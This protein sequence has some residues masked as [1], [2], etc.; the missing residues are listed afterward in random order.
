MQ[1]DPPLI[2][3]RLV[4]RYKRFLADVEIEGQGVVV[5]HCPNPGRMTGLD[6][7]D[8]RVW[9]SRAG[10]LD[11]KLAF[12]LE[13]VEANGQ[14]T[15][16]NTHR[17]N[18]LAREALALGRIEALGAYDEVRAEVA[19]HEKSRVDFRLSAA[20]APPLWLEVKSVTLSRQSGLAEFPDTPSERA[21]RHVEALS[22]MI[23][24][25]DRAAI[26]FVV[27][28]SDCSAFRLAG[29][30]DPSFARAIRSARH[31][32][33]EIYALSVEASPERAEIGPALRVAA[34]DDGDLEFGPV[35]SV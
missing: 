29:D 28:R 22:A 4:R 6:A 7:T 20:G 21:A 33:L 18:S 3:A 25:G 16:V 34:S 10:R 23:A 8:T 13:Y 27:Q 15:G 1:F 24:K 2:E 26:L 12:T 30:I 31:S 19:Y 14:M 32:G 9:V 11:R 35:F 17:A 5:A